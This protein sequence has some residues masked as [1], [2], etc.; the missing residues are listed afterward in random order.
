MS[1][2]GVTEGQLSG[3]AEKAFA[4]KRILRVNPREVSVESLEG[5]LREAL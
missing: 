1:W 3:F 4:V 5:I 2:L